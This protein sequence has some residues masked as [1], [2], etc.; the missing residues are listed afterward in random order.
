MIIVIGT[1][2]TSKK[3]NGVE[4][5]D[6][7]KTGNLIKEARVKKNYTQR[8]LGDLL[9]VSN[10]AVSRWENGDSFPDVGIL[11]N[12]AA[13]LDVRIQ[14]IITGEAGLYDESV[15]EEGVYDES[16]VAEVVRAAKL[17]QKEKKR[18]TIKISVF[19]VA[20]LSCIFSGYSALGNNHI[21]LVDDSILLYLILMLFSFLLILAEYIL[22]IEDDKDD[23]GKFCKCMKMISLFSLAWG[24]VMTW[25]VLRMLINGHVPFGIELSLVGSFVNRQLIVLFI[26]N[27]V[28]TAL[29]VYR[30][31][32]KNEAIHWGWF[33]SIA[34]MYMSVLYGDMLHR[35]NSAQGAMESLAI[36]TLIVLVDV[37]ISLAVTKIIKTKE[38]YGK[39]NILP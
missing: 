22:Q 6:K 15:V 5:M 3:C 31:E 36:R 11:E 2:K 10:K 35:M 21:L 13:V 33:V 26:L 20:L 38:N 9:G 17:Q 19:M 7:K 29:E 8:E 24:I 4:P 18:K 37:G 30:Y 23:T 34:T 32:K 12:L 14:D 28:V 1:I 16:A 27:L 39:Q 25:C